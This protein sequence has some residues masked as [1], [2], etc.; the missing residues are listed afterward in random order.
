MLKQILFLAS[1]TL[2]LSANSALYDRGNGMIYDDALDIT[3]LQDANYAYTSGANTWD[4][5]KNHWSAARGW[6]ANLSYEGYDDWRLPTANLMSPTAPCYWL[7]DGSCDGGHNNTTSELGHLFYTSL[8]NS[9]F[10]DINGQELGNG[11]K[12]YSF[13]DAVS[14][15]TIS[16]LNVQAGYWFEELN[17]D[18]IDDGY[19]SWTF[20]MSSGAQS[21]AANGWMSHNAWAVRDGDVAAASSLVPVPAAAWLFSSALIGFFGLMRKPR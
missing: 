3:W 4:D 8:G 17:L 5:G 15:Q 16:F 18:P 10:Y 1:I 14:G 2:S 6:A 9:G 20:M 12:N 19:T 11:P 13:I 7:H 21:T